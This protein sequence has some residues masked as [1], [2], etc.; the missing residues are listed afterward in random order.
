MRRGGIRWIRILGHDHDAETTK[1]LHAPVM[2]RVRLTR[3]KLE[4]LP[5]N[6]LVCTLYLRE[7]KG[8]TH[9]HKHK[10]KHML[11]SGRIHREW[12][13]VT[14][15]ATSTNGVEHTRVSEHVANSHP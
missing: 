5:S 1:T 8:G 11:L 15:H 7:T 4:G 9:K 3:F 13:L 10:H 2:S 6:S 12:N 14:A